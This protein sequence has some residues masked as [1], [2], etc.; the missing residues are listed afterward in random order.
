VVPSS[1]PLAVSG[2]VLY[3]AQTFQPVVLRGVNVEGLE[4]YAQDQGNGQTAIVYSQDNADRVNASVADALD[5]YH[6]NLI[7]LPVN[8]DFWLG[9]APSVT[10]N[11][12]QAEVDKVINTAA[13]NG[14]YVMLDVQV[15]DRGTG[16]WTQA[17][18]YSMPDNNTTLFWMGAATKYG[19]NP[20]V[21][22]DPFNEPGHYDCTLGGYN[23]TPDQWKNGGMITES[24]SEFGNTPAYMSPGMQG[25][26][27]TIR[28]AGATNI[29]A[30]EP[31]GYAL[32]LTDI[33]NGTGL[34]DRL[35][36]LMYQVHIYPASSPQ[37]LGQLG[38]PPDL[39]KAEV[40]Q[41]L[42]L[43]PTVTSQYPIYIGEWGSD[44]SGANPYGIA[45]PD[46]KTW[47]NTMLT[48]LDSHP[49]YSWTAWSLNATPFLNN[50]DGSPTEDF[51]A[52]VQD[53]LTAHNTTSPS[54]IAVVPPT[55]TG[56]Y[57]LGVNPGFAVL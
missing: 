52:L 48:W 16:D 44:N 57:A 40:L 6:A 26:I 17:G 11:D 9:L 12:Y 14:A 2:N 21:L 36:N 28:D 39:S 37:L 41:Q 3:N 53:Y 24:V 46:A 10:A 8:E 18:Q 34:S 45:S 50:P 23:I 20:T 49:S 31:R 25:L 1:A 33:A 7:R 27:T 51:G 13:A 54:P 56:G 15:S 42:E 30:P 5:N 47:N 35:N 22:F 32:A 29:I 19:K 38:Q 55:P 4:G 43:S